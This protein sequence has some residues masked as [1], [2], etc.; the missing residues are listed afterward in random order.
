MGRAAPRRAAVAAAVLLGL[1]IAPQ[2][3][4]Q[5]HDIDA[6]LT[7]QLLL[8]YLQSERAIERKDQ[9]AYFST[10]SS[11]RVK[12]FEEMVSAGKVASLEA[13]FERIAKMQDPDAAEPL[14]QFSEQHGTE[15]ALV[16]VQPGASAAIPDGQPAPDDGIA[17]VIFVEEA[18]AWKRDREEWVFKP[19]WMS[20]A[21]FMY[22]MT[23]TNL[24][25]PSAW[26]GNTADATGDA[27][28]DITEVAFAN[29]AEFLVVRA[30]LA[31]APDP[32][33]AGPM[34]YF[35]TDRNPATGSTS[36]EG[37]G[38]KVSGWERRLQLSKSMDGEA[39]APWAYE[40]VPAE[41]PAPRTTVHF[42]QAKGWLQQQGAALLI[43]VPLVLL[44]V[45]PGDTVEF[46]VVDSW[47]ESAGTTSRGRYTLTG[48]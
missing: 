47:F 26:G 46:T 34:V 16:L 29:D 18:G 10:L 37:I 13:L 3:R 9:A 15:A 19:A 14:V 27:P 33:A 25:S 38:P 1:G 45:Q 42:D 11:A 21:A 7:Q 8:A 31:G 41:L 20:Q 30:M 32:N 28:N 24:A 40:V 6:P 48:G 39:E 17:R 43:K 36:R 35:D 2:A 23:P 5:R 4:A 12:R 22:S 44:D